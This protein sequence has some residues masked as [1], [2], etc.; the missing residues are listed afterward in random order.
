MIRLPPRGSEKSASGAIPVARN[1]LSVDWVRTAFRE[2]CLLRAGANRVRAYWFLGTGPGSGYRRP[3]VLRIFLRIWCLCSV[4][5]FHAAGRI[6]A[7]SA[8]ATA[9]AVPLEYSIHC[10]LAEPSHFFAV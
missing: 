10:R 8:L 4:A 9:A 2:G 1:S 6:L 5:V 7:L 3:N